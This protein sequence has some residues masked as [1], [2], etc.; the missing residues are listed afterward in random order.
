MGCVDA[1]LHACSLTI[2]A[3]SCLL[4]DPEKPGDKTAGEVI[5]AVRWGRPSPPDP[6]CCGTSNIP[7][8][9]SSQRRSID[10]VEL[11]ATEW[12]QERVSCLLRSDWLQL[13]LFYLVEYV[14]VADGEQRSGP[15]PRLQALR[16]PSA[17]QL[18]PG[19]E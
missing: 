19:L 1:I 12:T 18:V 9:K 5:I 2:L 11:S 7:R 10:K 17:N 14:R 15:D 16:S 8:V 3:L 13:L 4:E 6:C